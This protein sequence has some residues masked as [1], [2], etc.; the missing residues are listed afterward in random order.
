MGLGFLCVKYYR[1]IRSG[2]ASTRIYAYIRFT[3]I[4]RIHDSATMIPA[5]LADEMV[6]EY[7]R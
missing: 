4:T 6:W 1:R 3:V 2:I 5:S 7:N